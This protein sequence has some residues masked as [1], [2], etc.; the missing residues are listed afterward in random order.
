MAEKA[1]RWKGYERESCELV[2]PT[3]EISP[4]ASAD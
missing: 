4:E 1:F 2:V 3:I